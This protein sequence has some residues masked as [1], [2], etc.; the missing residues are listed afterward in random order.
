MLL[1]LIVLLSGSMH[2]Q[3][4]NLEK[5]DSLFNRL[6]ENEKAMGSIIISK[7]GKTIYSKSIGFSSIGSTSNSP[8]TNQTRY[9]IGSITK[10][11]TAT[12]VFQLIEENK[13][14]LHSPL[15]DY[16][17]EFPNA[18]D[19]TVEL[20]LNHRSGLY[21]FTNDPSYPEW[22]TDEKTPTEMLQL[23]SAYAP[24][25][26]PDERY[27]Y[28][29][30]NYVLLGYILEK[31]SGKSYNALLT[32]YIT[33]KIGLNDTYYG[34][35]TNR[36][37]HES[38]S[39]YYENGW[40]Q[41]P[42]TDMSIPHGAGAIVS[43]PADLTRFS[44]ALFSGQLISKNNLGKMIII[45]N[46]YGLGIVHLPFEEHDGYGHDGAI[47]GFGSMLIQFPDDHLSIAYCSNGQSYPI[48]EIMHGVQS[49]LFDK[50][51]TLPSF[52]TVQLAADE[53]KQFSGSYFCAALEL[54]VSIG[55]EQD[56][57]MAQAEGQDAFPLSPSN[58]NTFH[59][60]PAGIV[61]EFNE[62]NDG[63]L[64]LQGGQEY[65]FVKVK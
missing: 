16:F 58:S 52:R 50:Q 20:L 45:R 19:I 23:M 26:A 49:I 34:G 14:F 41:L 1:A 36:E 37:N 28:S 15:S 38:F 55:L 32:E 5:L 54:V 39:Y 12:L 33:T 64:L 40:Q 3:S 57:L 60:D 62:T 61:I 42:E 8:S 22:M 17:P 65:G 43:T 6:A 21:N 59:F 46:G 7:E 35:K 11:F 48:N 29:N 2:A 47:D 63:F 53:L 18:K 31:A 25:F 9:R 24:D 13:L 10:M 56:T 4:Y 51:Y 27:A 30:T 44:D